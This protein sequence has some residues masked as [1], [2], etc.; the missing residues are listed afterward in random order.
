MM[1]SPRNEPLRLRAMG[2]YREEA[3]RLN[4][5]KRKASSKRKLMA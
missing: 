3:C 4:V 5:V 1:W 2:F